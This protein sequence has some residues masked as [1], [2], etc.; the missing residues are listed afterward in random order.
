MP[1]KLQL[2]IPFL[3]P[4]VEDKCDR[5][6]ERFIERI[7]ANKGI[8]KAHISLSNGKPALCFHYDPNLISLERVQQAAKAAGME[9][10]RRY[11]HETL[12]IRG[13]DCAQCAAS[14]EHILNRLPGML[15]A[16]V[17]YAA[18]KMTVE[19]DSTQLTHD[20]VIHLI[21]SMGYTI[22]EQ[23]ASGWLR[24]N[25]EL[26][27]SILSGFFLL[28][29]LASQLYLHVP[30]PIPLI[31]FLLAYVFGGFDAFQH[32]LRA[33]LHLQFDIDFLMIVAA[34]GAAFLDKWAEGAFLLFLFGLG[35]ALEHYATGQARSAIYSLGTLTPKS[36]RVRRN[37]GEVELPVKDL[38]RGDVVIVRPG[39]RVPI[40][41]QVLSGSSSVDQSALTGE[42]MPAPKKEGDSLFAGSVN[43]NGS[44]EIEVTR[45]ATDTTLARI[46]QLVEEAQTQKSPT[47]NHIERF[48][49]IFVPVVMCSV[50]GVI[51]IPPLAGWLSW[52]EAFIRAMTLLVASSPCA[53][54]IAT[55]SA[56]LSGIAQAARHGVL[57]KGGV[58]LENLGTLKAMAFDK[59]GTITRGKPE[60]VALSAFGGLTNERLLQLAAAVESRANHPLAQAILAE[61]A[62]KHL[63][64]PPA[65]DLQAINGR[66]ATATVE[67]RTVRLGNPLLFSEAGILLPPEV[68]DSVQE[69]EEAGL[70]TTILLAGD[71]EWGII[72]ISDQ[73]RP[74]APQ[75]VVRLRA[76]GIED[77][78]MLTGDNPRIAASI[79]QSAGLDD[80]RA[81]LLPHEKVAAIQALAARFGKVAMIGDGVNDAPAL[82]SATVGIAMGACGTDVALETADIALMA[83][84]LTQLPFAVALSRQTRRI[85]TQNLI[86]SMGV[87]ALLIPASILGTAGI[88]LAIVFHEGSTLLVVL[89]A[90][91]LLRFKH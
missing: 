82:A 34:A 1:E 56:I 80:Y 90:L 11:R 8:E 19:Y 38:L 66:G 77:M 27:F 52:P 78:V 9:I 51:I 28:L 89:N 43:A 55:P 74:E 49:H 47:Q 54:A 31:F 6:V 63:D 57:I 25:G 48:E 72:G 40:D 23:K 35:H 46:V 14:V 91:R 33:A 85:I 76:L 7:A 18:E 16:S 17:N 73:L 22:D 13:M 3:L 45:L 87:I 5:C 36:A 21:K 2:E 62:E 70:T 50:L 32:G 69:L 20:G 68:T 53:I 29:G 42:S 4:G 30:V 61:A 83:D 39:E 81:G 37:G 26:A 41:G 58:H 24:Q 12:F 86:I 71:E 75:T 10:T 64:L 44:L 60:V 59:T 79:S 88:G 65:V 15:S 67:D 84:E